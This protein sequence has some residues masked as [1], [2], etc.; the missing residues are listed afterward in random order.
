MRIVR[1]AISSRR[2]KHGRKGFSQS[3]T[4]AMA[5]AN[6]QPLNATDPVVFES[7]LPYE[8]ARIHAAAMYCSDGRIGEHMDDFLQ[9]GLGLPRYDRIALPGGPAC[10]AGHPEALAEEHAVVD[11][12]KFLVDVHALKRIVLIQHEGCA[13]YGNR[14]ALEGRRLELV[15]RADLVRA[16]A[17]VARVTKV[18][19]IEAYF[20]RARPGAMALERVEV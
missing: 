3:Y 9:N 14:L 6:L 13:F 10:L 19:R 7:R 12:L 2:F 17:I 5:D 15:Q 4:L 20:M 18:D 8:Q 1:S 11:E 16:A